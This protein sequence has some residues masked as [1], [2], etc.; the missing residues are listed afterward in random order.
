[1]PGGPPLMMASTGFL[2]AANP[3]DGG[4]S[5]LGTCACC[6]NR[7]ILLTAAHCVPDPLVN[8]F[9][10]LP[11]EAG[12]RRILDV[13]RHP[14]SD[15]ALLLAEP[16]DPEPASAHVFNIA[17]DDWALVEGD[18]FQAFGYPVEGAETLGP[19]GRLFKGN[20]LRYFNYRDTHQRSYFAGELSIAA[21][22]GL[23]GGPVVI[24]RVQRPYLIAVVTM[25][26]KSYALLDSVEEV[27]RD[28]KTVRVE[29]SAVVTYGIAA[30]LT[31]KRI[32]SARPWRASNGVWRSRERAASDTSSAG[33][34][35]Q[36]RARPP[37]T[38]ARC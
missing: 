27:E 12:T 4:V 36:G 26:V 22:A 25:N 2:V 32:G 21:P 15:L 29:T 16:R 19:V 31:N 10:Q 20:F 38:P 23:S 13:V 34:T 5:Y 9:A 18:D 37:A 28:G 7:H 30:M 35:Q 24:E 33:A 3:P 17:A 1:M 8:V 11:A 6:F 14:A